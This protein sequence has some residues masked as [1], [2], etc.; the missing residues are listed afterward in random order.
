MTTVNSTIQPAL[1]QEYAS[2]SPG[3]ENYLEKYGKT[4]SQE[5]LRMLQEIVRATPD[6]LVSFVGAGISKPLGTSDWKSLMEALLAYAGE[7]TTR[8][9]EELIEKSAD[10]NLDPKDYPLVADWILGDLPSAD[11]FHELVSKFYSQHKL[12]T[13]SPIL[14][15]LVL[16][17]RIHLT[18]NFE[19]CLE[20]TY[21]HL[22]ELANYLHGTFS[23]SPTIRYFQGKASFPTSIHDHW[24][25]Y[26]HADHTANRYV[27]ADTTYREVYETQNDTFTTTEYIEHFYKG[28]HIVFAGFSFD[29]IYVKNCFTRISKD[30]RLGSVPG[31]SGNISVPLSS[32]R[33]HFLLLSSS[34]QNALWN[35]FRKKVEPGTEGLA[36]K[37]FFDH[38]KEMGVYPIVYSSG[39]HVFLERLFKNLCRV[40]RGR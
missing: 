12:Q 39:Q 40:K 11:D 17:I 24:I 37:R 14:E 23:H 9:Y 1:A 32:D 10:N 18:T 6:R 26:L 16:A 36:M 30:Y 21:D 4:Y 2:S 8:K 3:L 27:L 5:H 35:R 19:R 28:Y 33:K 29:D 34:G 13:T 15:Y 22:S 31:K 38:W 20:N 7:D 25:Y